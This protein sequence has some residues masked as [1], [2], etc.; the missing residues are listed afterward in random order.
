[1]D[2]LTALVRE[3][4]RR[5]T[6]AL[7]VLS[8][9]GDPD[10]AVLESG[11]LVLFD[12]GED[13]GPMPQHPLADTN[14]GLLGGLGVYGTHGDEDGE[15]GLEWLEPVPD[16]LGARLESRMFAEAREHG[17]GM[18]ALW[19]C[20]HALAEMLGS[21]KRYEAEHHDG[22]RLTFE[23]VSWYHEL[24][25][26]A[27]NALWRYRLRVWLTGL[28][29]RLASSTELAEARYEAVQR[30]GSVARLDA[31]VEAWVPDVTEQA[32]LQELM[33]QGFEVEAITQA[34]EQAVFRAQLDEG[35]L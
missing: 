13:P 23:L 15:P 12:D 16:E 7:E 6:T 33:R 19:G 2:E 26:H 28:G 17:S 34:L 14:E 9:G 32:R 21:C 5:V 10:R 11:L 8:A 20:Y 31:A 25:V 35:Y 27:P 22:V 18:D 3:T 30:L 24:L 4:R 1:M 29:E